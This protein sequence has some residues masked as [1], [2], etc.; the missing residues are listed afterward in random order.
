MKR[1]I[2]LEVEL[3]CG[4]TSLKSIRAKR[5]QVRKRE[6]AKGNERTNRI[7]SFNQNKNSNCHSV[8]LLV[9]LRKENYLLDQTTSGVPKQLRN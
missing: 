5:L 3:S 9:C 6:K 1:S 7:F 4:V 8:F 2:Y